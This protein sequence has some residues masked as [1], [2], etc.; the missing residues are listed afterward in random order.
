MALFKSVYFVSGLAAIAGLLFG[1][2]TGVISGAIL[3]I[4]QDFDLS[5][6]HIGLVVSA[7]LFGALLGSAFCSK[8]TDRL[9]RRGSLIIASCLFVLASL[10]AAMSNNAS[11]LMLSRLFLGIAIGISSLTAPLYLAEIAP[12]KARGFLVSLNQLAVTLGILGAYGVNYAFSA[13]GAWRVMLGLGAVPAAFLGI[14]LIFLPESPRWMV[15]S[16]QKE[17]AKIILDNLRA[18]EN[19]GAELLEIEQSIQHEKA[20]WASLFTPALKPALIIAMGLAFFQQV[21]G[22]NAIIYYAPSIFEQ[23]GLADASHA[24]LAT[25]SIGVV[26]VL[27]TILSLFLIDRLGRRP[28][29][30]IGLAGMCVSLALLGVGFN[31]WI[32]LVCLLAYIAFFAI[33][34][35]PIMWLMISEVFPL[36]QRGLGTSL[37]VCAQWGFNLIISGTFPIL[38]HEIGIDYTFWIYAFL[39]LIGLVFVI[40]KVPETKGKILEEIKF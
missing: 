12:A 19:T 22:I 40:K 7:V 5:P 27:F 38:L 31:I 32:S 2:D 21:T 3:F 8:I 11:E 35:G 17:K 16:G 29:L 15:L 25:V 28:L 39:C 4:R 10:G 26:N 18:G 20:S 23:S 6:A 1:Y 36:Q 24:I 33:S 13:E 34:I 30:I 9:G 37:A 14:A